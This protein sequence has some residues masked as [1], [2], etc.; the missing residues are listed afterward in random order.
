M[1]QSSNHNKPFSL[2]DI[3]RYH[4][5]TMSAEERHALEKAALDDPFLADALEGYA[6]ASTPK[7]DLERLKSRLNQRTG[8]NK[9]VPLFRGYKAWKIAALFLILAGSGWL[10]YQTIQPDYKKLAVSPEKKKAEADSTTNSVLSAP[11]SNVTSRN[12]TPQLKELVST[13]QKEN[14]TVKVQKEP[15]QQKIAKEEEQLKEP[16]VATAPAVPEKQESPKASMAEKNR[17]ARVLVSS[18][19]FSR[20]ISDSNSSLSSDSEG[21]GLEAFS[22]TKDSSARQPDSDQ[23][24]SAAVAQKPLS[25]NHLNEVVVIGYGNKE[26]REATSRSNTDIVEPVDGWLQFNEYIASHIQSTEKLNIAAVNGEVELSFR[27]NKKGRPVDI[28]VE[29]SLCDKCDQEAIRLLQDGPKWKRIGKARGSVKIRFTP[30][31]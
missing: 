15:S 8:R 7:A 24:K 20:R 30:G 6:F 31:P 10:I 13:D 2:R 11:P 21:K 3:E 5:G 28:K 1:D 27:V 26:K 22:E 25:D 19:G 18:N 9:T 16:D 29:Q 14:K 4:A 23:S 17:T 12:D